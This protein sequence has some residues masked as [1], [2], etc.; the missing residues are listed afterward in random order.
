LSA[1]EYKKT[2]LSNGLRIVTERIP[3]VRSVAL[4]IWVA[5]G[6]RDE[7]PANNGISHFVEHMV[8]KG[9]RKRSAREIAE[10]IES[11][12][13]YLNAFT[14]KEVTC[15]YAH[16]L[17]EDLAR[18]VDVLADLVTGPLFDEEEIQKEKGVVL[19]EINNLEDTPEELVHEQFLKDLFP[20]HPLGFSTLGTRESVAAL[21]RDD[22]VRYMKRNYTLDRIV[23]A[24][25]GNVKHQ[26]LVRLV[27]PALEPLPQVGGKRPLSTPTPGTRNHLEEA[28]ILQ[29]HLCV[30]TTS[31][32]YRDPRKFALLALNTLLGGGMSSRLFQTI[33]ETYGL[34]YTVYSFLD[35]LLDT[36]VFGIYVGTDKDKV[37]ACLELIVKELETLRHTE[38][39]AEELART[40]SQLKGNL[41]LGLESTSGRM[42]RL[43]KMELYVR[44][45]YTL[46]DIIEKIDAVR[47][48]DIYQVAN[49]LFLPERL[50]TTILK[51]KNDGG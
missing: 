48:A 25:S 31:Y 4:G 46:D 17:D 21:T 35:F 12:G 38:V 45:Y 16:L 5:T 51:P 23:V 7:T 30:G 33:R 1:S 28:S 15:F 40:K 47:A 43:A 36:G 19:E 2:V 8:F 34:A 37:D 13:G 14:S 22:L 29:A 32:P 44:S 3:H 41:M 10:C 42:N 27:Q 20:D 11:V 39:P 9:T 50:Q 49:E 6:T 26:E 18:A 24:A